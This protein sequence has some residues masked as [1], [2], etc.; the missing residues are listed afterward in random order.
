MEFKKQEWIGEWE[1]FELSITDT[2]PYM[3]S[4]WEEAQ[5]TAEAMAAQNPGVA[6]MAS[7][8]IKNFWQQACVT[9]TAQNPTCIGGWT[10]SDNETAKDVVEAA[11]KEGIVISWKDTAGNEIASAFYVVDEIIERGLEG[12]PNFI[13]K[14]E[15]IAEG[16]PF[17]YVLAMEPMPERKAVQNGGLLSHLHYQFASEK[18]SLIKEDK[19]L[20]NPRWYATMCAK[21]SLLA[22]CNIVRALH[23]LKAWEKL[24]E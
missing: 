11:E 16:S 12:K 14:A 19:T 1:N 15:K 22:R 9:V 6:A 20:V 10:I 2:N 7:H 13:F 3:Q 17:A 8:G 21:G 18:S 24:P 5:H 4:C 23:R